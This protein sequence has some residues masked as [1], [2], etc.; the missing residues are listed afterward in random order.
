MLDPKAPRLSQIPLGQRVGKSLRPLLSSAKRGM[1]TGTFYK[2]MKSKFAG[3]MPEKMAK[4]AALRYAVGTDSGLTDKKEKMAIKEMGKAELLAN[5]Y[6]DGSYYKTAMAMRDYH[7]AVSANGAKTETKSSVE[8]T[9]KTADSVQVDK[10]KAH[11]A[12]LDAKIFAER[13]ARVDEQN[14]NSTTSISRV[15]KKDSSNEMPSPIMQ[16]D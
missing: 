5:K 2:T 1:S 11:K 13:K 4:A 15:P 10:A 9:Q 14:K 3:V 7:A 16:L 8:Q 6:K 12:E